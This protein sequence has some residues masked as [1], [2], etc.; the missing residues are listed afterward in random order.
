[1]SSSSDESRPVQAV[2]M[3]DDV[4][5]DMPAITNQVPE[6]DMDEG[7]ESDINETPAMPAAATDQGPENDDDDG[8]GDEEMNEVP[9]QQPD[10][11]RPK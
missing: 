4:R 3:T 10:V 6:I 5:T 7:P 2:V 9:Q 8:H 1:M 11:S